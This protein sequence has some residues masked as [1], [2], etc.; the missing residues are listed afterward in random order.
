MVR[1]VVGGGLKTTNAW[2]LIKLFIIWL[3]SSHGRNWVQ[4]LGGKLKVKHCVCQFLAYL[5]EKGPEVVDTER[6]E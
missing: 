3:S 4:G 5:F 1:A 6:L 2:W